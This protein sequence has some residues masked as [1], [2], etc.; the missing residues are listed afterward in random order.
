[1]RYYQ[2]MEKFIIQGGKPLQGIIEVRGAKN[3]A[4]PILAAC[5]LT[6]RACI[7][8][9][10]PLIKD[11]F[12][13]LE[14]LESMGVEINW[15]GKRKIKVEAKTID[16][17][18]MNHD[19]VCQ[20]RSSILLIGPCLARFGE[21]K[22]PH[23]G[24][25]IIG[26]RPLGIHLDALA[27]LGVEVKQDKD[28]YLLTAKRELPAKN[29]EIVLK[30]FSVTATENLMMA[31]ALTPAKT[32]IKIAAAEPHVQDLAK[33]LS[34]L[35]VKIEGSG[36]HTLII[37]GRRKL[38][39][40]NHTLI[41][42]SIEAGTFIIIGAATRG[43]VVVKNIISEHLDLVLEKLKEM[44][45]SFTLKENPSTQLQNICLKPSA[46]L[47]S[48]KIEARV[49]PGIP[50]DLQPLFAVLATQAEG[51]SLIHDT[52]FEGRLKYIDELSKMGA[53]AVLC[54]PHRALI[55]GPT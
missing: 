14:I 19:L 17:S 32:R 26:A 43:K 12:K 25:C 37:K 36:T 30:E 53:N 24:G 52:L 38:S 16:P 15:L 55:T 23:P 20:L 5:L 28:F 35:G 11:V 47:K 3:A 45:V 27:S 2:S 50:T 39:G 46:M 10:L 40:A 22:I 42:D 54:D 49:Y 13:M 44:N 1:M 48:T 6:K 7:I 4:T 51:T 8:D 34:K 18:K 21:I 29:K 31:S 41:P 9:N 33:F